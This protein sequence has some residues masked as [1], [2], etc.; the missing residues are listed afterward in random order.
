M[1]S[2]ITILCLASFFFSFSQSE[3]EKVVQASLDAYNAHD[4]EKFIS[5][6]SEDIE[7]YELHESEPNVKGITEVRKRYKDYFDAS[8]NLHSEIKNRMVFGNKIIDYEYIT[9]A[10]G[11]KEPYELIFMYE[12][13]NG[14]IIR[15]TAIRKEK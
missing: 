8:P 9:G 14:K 12:V 13:E 6:F 4:F 3:A 7:M 2:L 5:F 11:S 10:R 15:T 1:R